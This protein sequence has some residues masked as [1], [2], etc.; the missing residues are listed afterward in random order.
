[1]RVTLKITRAGSTSVASMS[2]PKKQPLHLIVKQG[3]IVILS[4]YSPVCEI[5]HN[6]FDHVQYS[7]VIRYW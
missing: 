7:P 4:L 6:V 5:S 3:I 2:Y 1:M